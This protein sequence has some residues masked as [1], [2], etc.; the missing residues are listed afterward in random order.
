MRSGAAAEA[1]EDLAQEALLTVW[2]KAAYFDPARA[3]ASAWIFTIARNLRIDRLRGDK[4]AKLYAPYETV[5]PEVP[6]RPDHALDAAERDE[7]VR[8]ALEEL[9]PEQ[10][11]V[12]A[13]FVLRRPRPWRYRGSAQSAA[14]HGQIA[15][16]S[17]HGRGCAICSVTCN[18][19]HASS[20]RRD[21][22]GF[23][24]GHARRGPRPRGRD[25]S[26][27]LRAMPQCRACASS[28]PAARCWTRP[29]TGCDVARRLAAR[30]GALG[31]A[32][33]HSARDRRR[34]RRRA[35]FRRRC[36]AMRWGRG[37]GSGAACNGARSMSRPTRAF[38]SS[39]SR[40]RPER[41]C[42]GIAIPARNGP[43]SS[44][45]RSRHDLG[46]YGAGDFDEADETRRARSGGGGRRWAA[47][48]W[49]RCRAHIE[50]QGWLGRLMQPFVRI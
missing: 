39:C 28:R 13:A 29:Q 36:R 32:R 34:R 15:G 8:A 22:G 45:A 5:E 11:R 30:D 2:R 25:A 31:A 9:P 16:S 20:K 40:P 46:R 37:A 12:V 48:A 19:H 49:W 33:Y 41:N 23:C 21:S 24:L 44:K 6:E 18:D 3:S 43:A 10:V 35:I 50:L 1:A 27:A 42:R 14:G 47:S 4:R 7:R 26:V 38:A 17:R